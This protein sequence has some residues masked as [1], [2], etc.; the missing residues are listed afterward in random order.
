MFH[1]KRSGERSAGG[2]ET[3]LAH[4]CLRGEDGHRA[5]TDAA[6]GRVDADEESGRILLLA[7]GIALVVVA[8]VLTSIAATSVHM[9]RRQLL[10]CADAVALSVAGSASANDYYAGV[11]G[12]IMLTDPS[13]AAT[14]VFAKLSATT[15]NVGARSWFEGAR[16]ED[17][18]AVVELGMNPQMSVYGAVL[19]FI[20]KPLEVRVLSSAKMH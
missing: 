18:E 9:Q 14:E 4:A 5:D 1:L 17:G 12:Q 10:T 20:N 8:L 19:D 13:V 15:C 7:L 11:N 3:R 2:T 16:L 6:C